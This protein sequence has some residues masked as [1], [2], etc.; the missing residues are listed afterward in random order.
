MESKHGRTS[1]GIGK[2]IGLYV[3]EQRSVNELLYI[4]SWLCVSWDSWDHSGQ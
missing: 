4:L 3:T 1:T 2:T